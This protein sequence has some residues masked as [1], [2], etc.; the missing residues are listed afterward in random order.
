MFPEIE[1]QNTVWEENGSY[2]SFHHIAHGKL[3][4]FGATVQV[5]HVLILHIFRDF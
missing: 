4:K 1:F 3:N 2:F 5:Y